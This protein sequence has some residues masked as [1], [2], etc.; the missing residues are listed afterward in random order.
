MEDWVSVYRDTNESKTVTLD[1]EESRLFVKK[2]LHIGAFNITFRKVNGDI[3]VMRCT[4]C[5]ASIPQGNRVH[6]EDDEPFAEDKKVARDAK[7]LIVYDLDKE[8]WRSMRWESIKS[9]NQVA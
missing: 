5:G 2:A 7:V 4:L 9:I 1:S 6:K 3:R 8:G